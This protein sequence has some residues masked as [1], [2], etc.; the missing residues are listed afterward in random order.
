MVNI[1]E[2]ILILDPNFVI[3]KLSKR[4]NTKL[5]IVDDKLIVGQHCHQIIFK[6]STPC[7]NCPV[8]RS[9]AYHTPVEEELP[10]DAMSTRRVSATPLFDDQGR[11]TAVIV[12][13]LGDL[14]AHP[15]FNAQHLD[16]E[17]GN[18]R[19]TSPYVQTPK[20]LADKLY[21]VI[22]I[23]REF[24]ILLMSKSVETL[25]GQSGIYGIGQNLF[26]VLPFYTQFAIR[27]K[28]ERFLYNEKEERLTF[29]ER[30]DYYA[31]EWVQY[32]I[33]R[34]STRGRTDALLIISRPID[35]IK[36]ERKQQTSRDVLRMMSHF[37]AKTAH[38][39]KNPLSLL[40]TNLEFI[41]ADMISVDSMDTTFKLM[42]YIDV[43]Q[44]QIQK[45]VAILDTLNSLKL[46]KLSTIDEINPGQ[47]LTRSI[48]MALMSRTS[49]KHEIIDTIAD[50]LPPLY[51]S[52]P[53]L[54]RAFIELFKALLSYAGDQGKLYVSLTYVGENKDQFILKIRVQAVLE[55][56]GDLEKLLEAFFSPEHRL[57]AKSMGLVIS[58]AT[59]LNHNGIMEVLQSKEGE[60]EVLI[61]LPR[62]TLP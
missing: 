13:C 43:M 33:T 53:N 36:L 56:F 18:G 30:A 48:S 17:S 51:G 34:L 55:N 39:I 11:A 21:R 60:T 9:M 4:L 54:E 3:R 50:D 28:I 19:Y 20:E 14:K 46:N 7:E 45:I 37:S 31:E 47:L 52:D 16:A 10:V 22:L 62:S 57:E 35:R 38:E 61:K 41:K 12:D 26:T 40:S 1:G 15:V 59:V 27:E 23:D 25:V 44:I 49:T 32:E 6:S 2:N 8:F 5:G 24:T 58:Y 42:D 29:E